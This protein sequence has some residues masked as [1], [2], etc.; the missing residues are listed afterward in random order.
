[1]NVIVM[2]RVSAQKYS[3]EPHKNTSI[4]ISI[5]D[6]QSEPNH[7]KNDANNGIKAILKV[8]FEDVDYPNPNAISQETANKIAMFIVNNKDNVNDIIV[9][10]EAGISRSAGC[11][12]AILKFFTG[13][14]SKIFDNSYYCPNKTVYRMVIDAFLDLVPEQLVIKTA[15]R[16]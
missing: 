4:I 13:D 6:P 8:S 9:H 16:E 14:D 7:F 2:N 11:A 3:T 15:R 12:A 10:C 1:M 5:T